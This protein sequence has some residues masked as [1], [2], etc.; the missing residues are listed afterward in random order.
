[1]SAPSW[2]SISTLS[3]HERRD[4]LQLAEYDAVTVRARRVFGQDYEPAP[5]AETEARLK[6]EASTRDEAFR[7]REAQGETVVWPLGTCAP[8]GKKPWLE[9]VPLRRGVEAMA[10]LPIKLL[11]MLDDEAWTTGRFKLVDETDHR[12]HWLMEGIEIFERSDDM[13]DAHIAHTYGASDS[14]DPVHS[15]GP[16]SVAGGWWTLHQAVAWIVTKDR[17]LVDDMPAR[18]RHFGRNGQNGCLQ[19]WAELAGHACVRA[20][21][22]AD[23]SFFDALDRGREIL[24]VACEFGTV[25]ASGVDVQ[26][27]RR[28]P[29]P[30]FDFVGAEIWHGDGTALHQMMGLQGA[31]AIWRGIQFQAVDVQSLDTPTSA[32]LPTSPTD[33]PPPSSRP[34]AGKPRQVSNDASVNALDPSNDDLQDWARTFYAETGGDTGSRDWN[35]AGQA[36]LKA[37][38]PGVL[39]KKHAAADIATQLGYKRRYDR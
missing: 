8:I 24:R 19:A 25:R 29:V 14:Q 9:H 38:F 7:H 23:A 28:L 35:R 5:L 18:V 15:K 26:S 13:N 12:R 10:E 11:A 21:A 27:G 39:F 32:P 16:S 2:R 6:A 33:Y 20:S 22:P 37:A 17:L 3:A 31:P 1:M 4:V 36:A 34:E 30:A